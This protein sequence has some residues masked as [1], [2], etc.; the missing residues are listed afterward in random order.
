MQ[1]TEDKSSSRP[2]FVVIF[3][4]LL[5]ACLLFSPLGGNIKDFERELWGSGLYSVEEVNDPWGV[6]QIR[7]AVARVVMV[8]GLILL[9]ILLVVG[10]RNCIK[11]RRN[12]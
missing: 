4:L 3:E 2:L 8:C 7:S 1:D 11:D 9:P 6:F 12:E 10:I 5:L